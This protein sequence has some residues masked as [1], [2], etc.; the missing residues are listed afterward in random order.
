L[1]NSRDNLDLPRTVESVLIGSVPSRI[2]EIALLIMFTQ[3]NP[4][5]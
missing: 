5:K 2:V 4:P 1:D 3:S